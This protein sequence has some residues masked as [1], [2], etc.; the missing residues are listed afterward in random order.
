V[1]PQHRKRRGRTEPPREEPSSPALGTAPLPSI[2]S[3]TDDASTSLTTLLEEPL[4][5]NPPDAYE[6][7]PAPKDEARAREREDGTDKVLIGERATSVAPAQ[8]ESSSVWRDEIDVAIETAHEAR[9]QS[10]RAPA[11]RGPLLIVAGVIATLAIVSIVALAI[12]SGEDDAGTESGTGTGPN[13]DTDTDTDTDT[14]TGP[15]IGTEAEQPAVPRTSADAIAVLPAPT[16]EVLGENTW[17]RRLRAAELRTAARRHYT[18]RNWR[19]AQ[20]TFEES[21]AWD[22]TSVDAQ[23]QVSR[24]YQRLGEME[25]ALAWARRAIVTDPNDPRSHELLGDQLLMLGRNAEAADAYRA[26]IAIRPR[27]VRLRSRLRRMEEEQ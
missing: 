9:R 10:S 7:E 1:R 25:M 8:S 4:R 17:V 19:L 24:A 5:S 13:T 22:A 23:Q 2:R 14:S 27:D 3:L 18:Q 20:Q 15:G 26:G 21:L 12:G 6:P 16:P 11:T